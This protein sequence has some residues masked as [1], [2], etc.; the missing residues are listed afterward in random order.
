VSKKQPA[1][2]KRGGFL[3]LLRNL[4]LLALV[5]GAAAAWLVYGDYRGFASRELA[6]GDGEHLLEVKR[7][8]SFDD[9]LRRL[10]KLGVREGHD[11]YWKALAWELGVITR[12]Q[13][14]EYAVGHGLTP[15]Q[16][17]E[18]LENGDVIQHRF[19]IVEGWN[20][21][22]L[23]LALAR[24]AGLE[25]TLAG[26]PDA[27]VMKRIGAPGQHPE[28]RFL[29]ET[30]NSTKGLSDADLLKRTHA[31]MEN[32]LQAAW[33]KRAADLPLKTPDEALVLASI[34][35]K[36]TGVAAERPQIAGVFI[37]RLRLGMRLQTDPTV[38]YGLGPAFD[39]NLT[40]KHLEE[41]TQYNTYARFGLPPT[42][43]SMPGRAALEAAVNPAPGESL[44]FVARGDGSHEFTANLADH[45]R[46]VARW[47]LGRR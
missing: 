47:Q 30:Y 37:R 25:Q 4:F 27:E 28:G 19:T 44:Y 12:L 39:G 6:L 46:A 40:R 15:A 21:R 20:F 8:D 35:E 32:A 7:G 33:G 14:G 29:P 42:P 23:R 24:E 16:L 2:R 38:I 17:L 36:E 1:P 18:K 10:R 3:R 26:L 5:L 41:D 13:V 45:N 9:V 31:A 11:A 34:V 43:I 22:E